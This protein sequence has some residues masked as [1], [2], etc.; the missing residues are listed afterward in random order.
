VKGRKRHLLVDTLGL[1]WS[2]TVTPANVQDKTG[3]RRLL[4]AA[5]PRLPRLRR[6]WADGGYDS[7]PLVAELA[8]RGCA[9]EITRPPAGSHG[10][11]TVPKR[12]VVERTFAWLTHQRR[13]RAD[14]E[15]LPAVVE[16]FIDLTMI[17]LLTRRLARYAH[18]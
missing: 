13:L 16:A 15:H 2:R 1:V 18:S 8:A 5:L 3:A 17:R 4:A 12:W 6:L 11:T 14:Y 9:L 7:A 10:F